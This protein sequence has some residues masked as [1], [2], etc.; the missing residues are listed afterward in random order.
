MEREITITV[1]GKEIPLNEFVEEMTEGLLRALV[2]PLKEA[3]ENGEI[4]IR[5]AKR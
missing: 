5:V 2:A 1:D 3:D 4:I